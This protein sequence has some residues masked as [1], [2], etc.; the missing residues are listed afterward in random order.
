MST[1]VPFA[2]LYIL[3]SLRKSI[4]VDADYIVMEEGG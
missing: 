1:F 2:V 3:Y 4:P